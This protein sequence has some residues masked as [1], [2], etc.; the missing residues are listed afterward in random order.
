MTEIDTQQSFRY[1]ADILHTLNS[2]SQYEE[3]LH[4]IVDRTFRL[5]H[6]Q[7]CAIALINPKTEYVQIDNYHGLSLAFCNAFRKRIAAK[8]IG[9]LLWTGTPILLTGHEADRSLAEEI[10]LEHPFVSCVCL[11]I[12]AHH[13]T[14]GY[15]HVDSAEFDAFSEGA[16]GFLKMCAESAGI[17]VLKTRLL[18]ENFHLEQVDRETGLSKYPPFVEKLDAVLVRGEQLGEQSSLLL[19][20]VDNFKDIVNTFGYDTSR[21]V[22]KELGQRVRAILRPIDCA[23]RYGFD[24]IA[25]LIENTDL[26]GALASADKLRQNIADVP[27]TSRLV[28]STVSIGVASSPASGRTCDALLLAAKKALLDAQRSGRN[29]VAA[30]QEEHAEEG[31]Q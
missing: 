5:T 22:L 1:L 7:T 26:R 30:S 20:D 8:A 13:R 25:V 23:C 15:L 6:C 31:V 11:Q 10:R 9:Q 24:E 14:I 18:E 3:V 17:A 19:L 28:P 2:T 27:F 4:L 12:A 29:T 21:Q 16:V